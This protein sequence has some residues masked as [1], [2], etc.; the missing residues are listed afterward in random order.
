[1]KNWFFWTVVLEKTLESPLDCKEIQPVHSEGDQSWIFI[2]GTDAE[3]EA[4]ILWPPDLK[5]WLTWK[6]PNAGKGWRQEEKGTTEDQTVGWY[7]QLNG[8]EFEQAL[9]DS[10]GQGIL[11]CN[12]PWGWKSRTW[13]SNWTTRTPA[14]SSHH[15]DQPTVINM[16]ARSS[17][18]KKDYSSLK[19]V[20]ISQQ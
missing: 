19:R 17:S 3:A 20:S 4:L 15:F 11:V 5:S 6:D 14:F 12:N 8:H 16:E 13:L 18:S 7:H 1:M 10:E 9:G 2:W